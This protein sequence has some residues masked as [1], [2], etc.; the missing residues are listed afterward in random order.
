MERKKQ[1]TY[2][3]SFR[4]TI[5]FAIYPD[6]FP[7]T[8]SKMINQS[9]LRSMQ[10]FG[11]SFHVRNV[12]TT[13]IIFFD[14]CKRF[15]CSWQIDICYKVMNEAARIFRDIY[16]GSC[17]KVCILLPTAIIAYDESF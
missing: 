3:A 6:D 12:L 10:N 17:M 5:Q 16:T 11:S 2:K 8:S 1:T 4:S 9:A 7:R 15:I 13:R 14:L